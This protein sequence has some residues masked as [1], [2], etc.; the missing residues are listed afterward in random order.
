ML[1]HLVG[2]FLCFNLVHLQQPIDVNLARIMTYIAHGESMSNIRQRGKTWTAS[3]YRRGIRQCK[4]FPTYDLAKD[5]A[6]SVEERI[7]R[8]HSAAQ[9]EAYRNEHDFVPPIDTKTSLDFD[10]IYASAQRVRQITGIYFLFA[11]N[12]LVYV[13]QSMDVLG[14]ISQHHGCKPFDRLAIIECHRSELDRIESHYINKF[15]PR[16]NIRGI[17]QE[18]R[19]RLEG[20]CTA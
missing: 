18:D 5:W 9:I 13:G 15:R 7:I 1:Y 14:R 20:C 10:A 2:T 17:N 19:K 3:I 12:E 8:E 6:D 16:M 4:T 11:D